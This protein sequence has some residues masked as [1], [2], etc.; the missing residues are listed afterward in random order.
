M[1]RYRLLKQQEVER[2][3]VSDAWTTRLPNQIVGEIASQQGF[4]GEGG[5]G[6]DGRRRRRRKRKMGVR[7]CVRRQCEVGEWGH[8]ETRRD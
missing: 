7:H 8:P 5:R 2:E 4:G 3:G 1:L 6:R